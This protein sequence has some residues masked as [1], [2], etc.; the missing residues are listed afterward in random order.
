MRLLLPLCVAATG[1]AAVHKVPPSQLKAKLADASSIKLAGSDHHSPIG[2]NAATYAELPAE[3]IEYVEV[4]NHKKGAIF[5]MVAG[6]QGGAVAGL[7][8]SL[9]APYESDCEG[10]ECLDDIGEAVFRPYL[11]IGAGALAGGLAGAL[12][13]YAAGLPE[14]YTPLIGPGPDGGVRAGLSLRF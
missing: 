3:Q 9:V 6:A 5:G 4:R 2:P 13:G 8:Y 14:R 12:I 11:Y 1:C 10:F 7:I